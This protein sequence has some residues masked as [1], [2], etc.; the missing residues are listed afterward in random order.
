MERVPIR[1][2]EAPFWEEAC[3]ATSARLLRGVTICARLLF[4]HGKHEYSDDE[5]DGSR[6]PAS[7]L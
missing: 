1:Q 7:R 4:L 3:K 5:P 2:F 6:L